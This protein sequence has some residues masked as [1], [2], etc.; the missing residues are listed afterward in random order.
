MQRPRPLASRGLG[1]FCSSAVFALVL[2]LSTGGAHGG[3]D[4]MGEGVAWGGSDAVGEESYSP[5][6]DESI[7]RDVYFGDLHVHSSWS[8]DAGNMGNRRDR[9]GTL[10]PQA[11]ERTVGSDVGSQRQRL[12]RRAQHHR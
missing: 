4:A 6:A 1:P 3:S 8:A 9:T 7:P 2:G 5:Y 10:R 11:P 12:A